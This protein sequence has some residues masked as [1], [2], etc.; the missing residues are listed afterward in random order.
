M[1]LQSV[2]QWTRSGAVEAT[3]KLSSSQE[4]TAFSYL[5][6]ISHNM[7]PIWLLAH[8]PKLLLSQDTFTR[9]EQAGS[10]SK[11]YGRGAGRKD[12]RCILALLMHH[13]N[14]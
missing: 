6:A 13:T 4:I 10:R 14:R 7:D 5:R 2:V 11:C 9:C 3:G 1:V 12:L 8:P